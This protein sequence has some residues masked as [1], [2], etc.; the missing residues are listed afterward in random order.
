MNITYGKATKNDIEQIVQFCKQLI[1]DYENFETIDYEKVLSWIT[2]KIEAQ[3]EEYTVIY[4]EGRKA[5]YYHFYRNDEEKYEL[6]DLYLFPEFQ[7][8][9]IG[10]MVIKKCCLA[11]N[12]PVMLYVFVRNDRAVTLYKRLGF[13]IIKK[14]NESRYI[15]VKQ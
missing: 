6:D 7:N 8:K 2:K 4:E 14:I 13:E 12:E 15:M 9:G 1:D 10:S 5:G 3:I 11:V